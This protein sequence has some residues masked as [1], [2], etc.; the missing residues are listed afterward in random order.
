MSHASDMKRKYFRWGATGAVLSLFLLAGGWFFMPLFQLGS[1]LLMVSVMPLAAGLNVGGGFLLGLSAAAIWT[2]ARSFIVVPE[3]ALLT[4]SHLL[5]VV[6]M[7]TIGV[8]SGGLLNTPIEAEISVARRLSTGGPV[9]RTDFEI[10]KRQDQ[11]PMQ[12]IMKNAL[13]LYRSWLTEWDQKEE[14]WSAF[15]QFI[16]EMMQQGLGARHVRCYRV[17][18]DGALYS[19]SR[20][21]SDEPAKTTAEKLINH[22]LTTGRRYWAASEL[23][24]PILRELAEAGDDSPTW[25]FSI[26]H[27]NKPIGL[28]TV[29]NFTEP[30]QDSIKLELAADLVE[31]FWQHTWQAN[32]LRLARLMDHASGVLNR[33]EFL[34]VQNEM[35]QS[36]YESYEPVVV[37]AVCLEGLRGLDDTGQWQKRD[38]VVEKVG[39]VLRDGLRKEDI[40]GRFSDSLFVAILRRLDVPLAELITQKQLRC[41]EEALAQLQVD[42]M[43]GIRAGLAGSGLEQVPGEQLLQQAFAALSNARKAQQRLS[44]NCTKEELAEANV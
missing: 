40:V 1:A 24:G 26:R 21:T 5:T 8:L 12:N 13:S 2:I 3:E 32:E 14:P 18:Q 44:S 42:S 31:E 35:I 39:L 38:A 28:M 43:I 29:K 11:A 37:L 6:V 20:G 30:V 9:V 23:T 19:L 10:R 33:S 25:V 36:S 7:V 34:T 27:H 15:D 22:V 41:V 17:G 4:S 16:R